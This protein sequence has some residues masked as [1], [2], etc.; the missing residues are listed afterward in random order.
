MANRWSKCILAVI[1][2]S[3]YLGIESFSMK[4]TY[5]LDLNNALTDLFDKTVFDASGLDKEYNHLLLWEGKPYV[6][7][8]IMQN[9]KGVTNE[10]MAKIIAGVNKSLG[11]D[12]SIKLRGVANP[13]DADILILSFKD[14]NN[15]FTG[16]ID[17]LLKRKFKFTDDEYD[18]DFSEILRYLYSHSHYYYWALPDITYNSTGKMEIG[19]YLAIIKPEKN[20]FQNN[21]TKIIFESLGYGNRHYVENILK[22]AHTQIFNNRIEGPDLAIL[23]FL[24][25]SE[26]K[27]GMPRKDALGLFRRWLTSEYFQTKI[28]LKSDDK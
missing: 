19:G 2:L 22:S 25:N 3:L 8:H 7:F 15:F 14:K 23:H 5:A 24:Y 1:C 4:N 27:N 10:W 13:F 6:S 12:A 16:N 28:D 26:V 18:K 9:V 20:I 21:L 17:I 11:P